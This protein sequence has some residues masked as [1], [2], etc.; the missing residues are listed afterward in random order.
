MFEKSLYAQST[1]K[2]GITELHNVHLFKNK[3]YLIAGNFNKTFRF[4]TI[5]DTNKAFN[6]MFFVHLDSMNKL[7]NYEKFEVQ[8]YVRIVKCQSN[9]TGT[10]Q[11]LV[12][13]NKGIE[14]N[15]GQ[16]EQNK[17]WGLAY[18]EYK[19]SLKFYL[20]DSADNFDLIDFKAGE[21]TSS[22]LFKKSEKSDIIIRE[23]SNGS[24]KTNDLFN[25]YSA[26]KEADYLSSGI[27]DE[28]NIYFVQR[29]NALQLI[30]LNHSQSLWKDYSLDLSEYRFI[31]S[32]HFDSTVDIF[33]QREDS[34]FVLPLKINRKPSIY[35]IKFVFTGDVINLN[36]IYYGNSKYY[37]GTTKSYISTSSD[38]LNFDSSGNSFIIADF[39]DDEQLDTTCVVNNYNIFGLIISGE[40]ST[41]Y[42]DE[43]IIPESNSNFVSVEN[44]EEI[45]FSF[46]TF[47]MP[48]R[49]D[50]DKNHV[51]KEDVLLVYPNPYIYGESSLKIKILQENSNSGD[52][53]IF[54]P[55]GQLVYSNSMG[56]LNDAINIEFDEDVFKPGI[57]IVKVQVLSKTYTSRL[58]IQQY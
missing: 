32:S 50:H 51:L 41:L 43:L 19:D 36:T 48:K 54:N 23:F 26:Q 1:A 58:I 53:Q 44:T 56:I 4:S 9:S 25:I 6:A 5:N 7:L 34:I 21:K 33:L 15:S 45:N 52:I 40:Q 47:T 24:V 18:F 39:E 57:Y 42:F 35:D 8:G 13:F 49:M 37:Y 3:T 17:N 16:I 11:G 14:T 46:K 38:T 55:L 30:F 27:I 20:I 2:N 29:T 28:S 12:L 22:I 10:Y 31:N